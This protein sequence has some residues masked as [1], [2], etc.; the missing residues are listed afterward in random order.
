MVNSS[1]DIWTSMY[2]SY[3]FISNNYIC[4]YFYFLT[5]V[6]FVLLI[7][8]FVGLNEREEKEESCKK[9]HEIIF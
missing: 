6:I 2:L 1:C 5:S 4:I 7:H 9:F 3:P 8:Y